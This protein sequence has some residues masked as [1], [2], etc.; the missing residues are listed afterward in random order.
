MSTKGTEFPVSD[1]VG[2]RKLIAPSSELPWAG[3]PV[4]IVLDIE[5][6]TRTRLRDGDNPIWF[7]RLH[8]HFQE[9]SR[10]S[11]GVS[12]REY[13]ARRHSDKIDALPESAEFEKL[14]SKN[15]LPEHGDSAQPRSAAAA[16]RVAR[17][18]QPVHFEDFDGH[19]FERL[20]FAFHLRTEKWRTLEWYGQSGSDL[21]RDIWGVRETARS[22]CIQCV[23]RKSIAAA[24]ITRDLDKIVCARGGIPDAVLVV[25]ASSVSAKLRDKVKEHAQR[26]G[27]PQC[28]IWSGHEF[29]ERLRRDAESL[30]RRF[31]DGE[32]FPDDLDG[33][34]RVAD[35]E[36]ANDAA[37]I[38]RIIRVFDRP[39]FTTPFQQESSLPAFRQAIGDTIQA[40]NT[41][42]WQTR[43][44]K[45][46]E[47]LPSRHQLASEILR[48]ELSVVVH[49]LTELRARFDQ[50]IRDGEIRPC[51]C[52]KDDCPV[53]FLSSAAAHRMDSLRTRIISRVHALHRKSQFAQSS[54]KSVSVIGSTN[55]GIIANQV[56]IRSSGRRR[57]AVI[58]PDSIG[59]DPRKYNY[60]EYLIKQLTEFRRTGGSYG[61]RRG[62]RVHPGATRRI[63]ESQLGGLPKD[64]HVDRFEEVV[65]YLKEKID[66][67]AL[68]RNNKKRN[69]QN[70]HSFEEHGA[71]RRVSIEGR[72][73]G[74]GRAEGDA[75]A[76]N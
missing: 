10:P 50:F 1:D 52:G 51:P 6:R 60:I 11:D 42:V 9:R 8:K 73:E 33:L 26:K 45:E 37:V 38:E 64:L 72:T 49:D 62:G 66:A 71:P 69:F 21:G 65:I 24:K 27:I 3:N 16:S 13:V 40:L 54:A 18:V 63:L 53:F 43:D 12:F 68:G 28:D 7:I 36:P 5:A 46:I 58:V 31:V 19:Q 61:Q 34:R 47:R 22:L 59:S 29:E 70:Y 48:D 14:R 75:R 44:G 2:S 56:T 23:N 67:T 25:C 76:A 15:K 39:A 55:S 41:G 4:P 35:S 57:Q 20:V 32:I 17:T 30:L 74:D